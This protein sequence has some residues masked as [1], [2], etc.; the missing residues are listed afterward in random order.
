[1]RRVI[2]LR[3]AGLA[4]LAELEL[5]GALRRADAKELVGALRRPEVV[6]IVAT[7]FPDDV[8]AWHLPFIERHTV[9]CV[10]R[11]IAPD[12]PT[13]GGAARAGLRLALACWGK[14]T[15]YIRWQRGA[16]RNRQSAEGDGCPDGMAIHLIQNHEVRR[17]TGSA[18]PVKKAPERGGQRLLSYGELP[19]L[20]RHSPAVSTRR[21][22]A[23]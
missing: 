5:G 18:F 3:S 15:G 19:D 21:A 16:A 7:A 9:A 1:M 10:R 11:V 23:S 20:V 4:R 2:D 14:E 8:E 13:I 17:V 12:Q 22:I 6:T